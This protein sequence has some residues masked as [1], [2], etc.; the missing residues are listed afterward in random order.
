MNPMTKVRI[1]KLT[2]NVGAG[3]D[4]EKLKK[5]IT[6]LKK[7]S[8]AKVVKTFT[9]KRIPGWGVRPGL[10]L[11]A[12]TTIRGPKIKILLARLL[13][14]KENHLGENAFDDNGNVSFGNSEYINI[15][16]MKYDPDIGM[17]GF[18][19]SLTLERAGFRVKKRRVKPNKIPAK[20][21]VNKQDA[22]DFMKSEFGIQ[23]GDKE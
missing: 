11:G 1:E 16:D 19:V 22:I 23:V 9:T 8:E 7:I 18:E 4:E 6:L 17:L 15:P 2:L 12:K 21:K 14:A 13:E 3:K 20:H 5:G 10:A